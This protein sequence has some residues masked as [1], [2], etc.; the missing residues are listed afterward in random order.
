MN[1]FK[2]ETTCQNKIVGIFKNGYNFPK[3]SYDNFLGA[4]EASTEYIKV[5]IKLN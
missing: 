1:F 5:N 3:E 2:T 4:S